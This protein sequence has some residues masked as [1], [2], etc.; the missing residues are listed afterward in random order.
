[1][2]ERVRNSGTTL[3]ICRFLLITL[4]ALI[5]R[6]VFAQELPIAPVAPDVVSNDSEVPTSYLDGD[7]K[8]LTADLIKRVTDLEKSLKKREDADKKSADAASKRFVVRPFGRLNIDAVTFN[9]DRANKT[10]VGDAENGMDIRRLRLGVEGEGF[11]IFFYR[12]D[13][14]FVTFDASTSTRPTVFDAY[15]DTQQLPVIG[16]LRVGHFREPFSLERLNSTSD[17][18]FLE[19]ATAVNTLTPF[20]NLGVM[21]FDW[22]E[23]Q[24]ATWTYGVFNEN[25]NEFGEDRHDRTGIAATGRVTWLPWYDEDSNGRSLLHFGASYSYRRLGNHER[26][27]A[28]TPEITLKQGL[29]KTP[30][31]VDTGKRFFSDYHVAGCEFSTVL[32]S[33]SLQGEYIFLAGQA[34]SLAGAPKKFSQNAFL[35]GGYLE[36]SYWLT[37]ESRNYNRKLGIYGPVT[38]RTRF[39]SVKTDEGYQMGSGAWE[40]AARVSTIDLNNANITGGQLTDLNVGLNWYYAV[41]SRVMFDYIHAFLDRSNIHSN[42]DIFGVR[43]QY[44]F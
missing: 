8:G 38:P 1:M 11:D 22:N 5:S 27:F 41:R 32:G 25:T 24:T 10:Q 40:I 44:T 20:R 21:A 26:A 43:F 17:L 42:A 28:Q 16:N 2:R 12:L 18:P 23:C 35:H 13:V 39:F 37:G 29:T 3:L 9:Q 15:L 34:A 7:N 14:D 36:A 4:L 31:F 33:L 19:R 6:P 30:N